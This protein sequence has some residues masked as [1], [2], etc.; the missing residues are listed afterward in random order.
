MTWRRPR[1]GFRPFHN[2]ERSVSGIIDQSEEENE[3]DGG[4]GEHENVGKQAFVGLAQS[5]EWWWCERRTG[6]E[7]PLNAPSGS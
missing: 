4:D 2:S 5:T 1:S 3:R 7:L 6:A